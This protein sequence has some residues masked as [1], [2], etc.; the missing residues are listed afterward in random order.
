LIPFFFLYFT[1]L[2]ALI[3]L[4]FWI[5]LQFFNGAA[6]VVYSQAVGGVAWWAHIGGFFG[7]MLV[8]KL[9]RPRAKVSLRVY[10]S[11]RYDY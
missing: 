3:V 7:G 11:R 1:E 6:S 10:R 4:G 2:P 9:F 5:V 8:F